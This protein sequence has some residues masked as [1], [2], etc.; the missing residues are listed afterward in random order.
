M[1]AVTWALAGALAI[2]IL[3]IWWLATEIG[4]LEDQ[5][6]HT[7]PERCPHCRRALVPNSPRERRRFGG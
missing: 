7:P 3:A 5:I 4:M 2:A 6:M 1:T